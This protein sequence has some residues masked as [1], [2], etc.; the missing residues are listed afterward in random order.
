MA[1]KDESP[2]LTSLKELIPLQPWRTPA[3]PF[4]QNPYDQYMKVKEPIIK[5]GATVYWAPRSSILKSECDDDDDD[6]TNVKIPHEGFFDFIDKWVINKAHQWVDR[7]FG[8]L[9]SLPKYD[10]HRTTR[11]IKRPE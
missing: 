8:E 5:D 3:P 9:F 2:S 1:R 7:A 10:P 6:V 4:P 11:L